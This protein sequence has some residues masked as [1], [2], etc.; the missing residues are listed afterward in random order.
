MLFWRRYVRKA[1]RRKTII[2]NLKYIPHPRGKEE[3]PII[4]RSKWKK[5]FSAPRKTNALILLSPNTRSIF[6]IKFSR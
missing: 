6:R 3:V 1:I 5:V 2:I 4:L